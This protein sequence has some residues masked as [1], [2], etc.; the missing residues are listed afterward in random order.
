VLNAL[1][2]LRRDMTIHENKC[3]L[4]VTTECLQCANISKLKAN[5]WK[6]TQYITVHCWRSSLLSIVEGLHWKV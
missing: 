2:S 1:W 6:S 3:W 5:N 4:Y